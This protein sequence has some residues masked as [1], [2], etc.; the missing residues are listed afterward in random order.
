MVRQWFSVTAV[1]A[2]VMLTMATDSSQAQERR[3]GRRFRGN[4][5]EYVPG[6]PQMSGDVT[7]Y[8]P[9]PPG[10]PEASQVMI[11]VR[12]PAMDADISIGGE[13]T[14][15]KGMIRRYVSPPITP[16]RTYTYDINARWLENGREITRY[17]TLQVQAGQRLG[18]DLTRPTPEMMRPESQV[19]QERRSQYFSPGVNDR[20]VLLEVRI[21]ADADLLIGGQPTM[22]KGTLRRFVS[23]PIE[24]GRTFTY[25]LAGKWMDNGQPVNRSKTVDVHAGEVVPVDLTQA[26]AGQQTKDRHPEGQRET[27]D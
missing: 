4:N 18:I 24:S 22:Q 12:V 11:E 5:Y 15:Q 17:R 14:M 3:F 1:L 9:A 2:G 19:T 13:K 6:T 7:I 20:Q 26:S 25:D 16:G 10:T 8:P 23:P 27:R 21:P